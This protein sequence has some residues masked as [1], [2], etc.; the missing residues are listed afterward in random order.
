MHLNFEFFISRHIIKTGKGSL[1]RPPVRI[2]VIS[3]ALGTAVMIVS[4]AVLMGFQ[5]E[6]REKVSAF[7]AHV[8]I[9]AFDQNVSYETRPIAPEKEF[10]EALSQNQYVKHLQPFAT[11]AGIIRTKTDIQGVVF[12]GVDKT[13]DWTFF[14]NRLDEGRLPLFHDSTS[15]KEVL[16]SRK[17]ANM[18]NMKSGDDIRMYFVVEGE[19]QPRGRKFSIS[20]L[21]NTGLEEFDKMIVFGDLSHI[22]KLNGWAPYEVG[23]YELFI[24][25]FAK[26]DQA[27]ASIYQSTPYDLNARTVKEVFPQIFDWLELQ[28]VN[29]IIIISLMILVSVMAVTSSLLILILERTSFIGV[30]KAMGTQNWALRKIFLHVSGYVILKGMFWGNLIGLGICYLQSTYKILSLPQES[31]YMEYV[32]VSVHLGQVVTLNLGSFVICTLVLIIPT[33]VISSITPV[34]AIKYE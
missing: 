20:G 17:L 28:D 11:K 5:E 14:E 16:V 27:G 31:Y 15:S 4:L 2:A 33:M 21:Y 23:G 32:P 8:Q 34:N 22:R 18:L 19:A 3:V 26:L 1:A 10:L 24:K 7:N 9:T 30:L 6:I 25:D 13:F 12:K 29:V